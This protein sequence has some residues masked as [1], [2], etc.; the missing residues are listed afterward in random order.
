MSGTRD[1]LAMAAK[2]YPTSQPP[3]IDEFHTRDPVIE[4]I[5][6]ASSNK[7]V[8]YLE[9]ASEASSLYPPEPAPPR[10]F[11]PLPRRIPLNQPQQQQGSATARRLPPS[12]T[13]NSRSTST[14]T[15]TTSKQRAVQ[16]LHGEKRRAK[17]HKSEWKD[18]PYSN[19]FSLGSNF[20][21]L[22]FAMLVLFHSSPL[23]CHLLTLDV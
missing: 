7:F 9:A 20:L 23:T 22:P 13:S 10:P 2:L 18:L 1:F 15:N 16:V 8:Q 17:K 19:D 3:S 14:T 21:N 11:V 5:S 12:T 4:G 6:F